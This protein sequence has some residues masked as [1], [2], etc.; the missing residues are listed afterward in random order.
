M[1]Q[2]ECRDTHSFNLSA[3]LTQRS[4]IVPNAQLYALS[5]IASVTRILHQEPDILINRKINR[6]VGDR[7]KDPGSVLRRP[8]TAVG[9]FFGVLQHHTAARKPRLSLHTKDG[10]AGGNR[11]RAFALEGRSTTMIRQPQ[12]GGAVTRRRPF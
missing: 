1:R 5:S 6:H 4:R 8:F 11:T 3:E 12:S 7:L 9:D 2:F 10:A